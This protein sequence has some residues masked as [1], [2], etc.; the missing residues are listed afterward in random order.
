MVDV[1]NLVERQVSGHRAVSFSQR[2]LCA[3]VDERDQHSPLLVTP[4]EIL[5][6]PPPRGIEATPRRTRGG[7]RP[8]ASGPDQPHQRRRWADSR[9]HERRAGD[10][11]ARS[12]TFARRRSARALPLPRAYICICRAARTVGLTSTLR[13]IE[14]R[15]GQSPLRSPLKRASPAIGSTRTGS[16]SVVHGA[17][18]AYADGAALARRELLGQRPIRSSRRAIGRVFMCRGSSS[19]LPRGAP[20]SSLV[21]QPARASRRLLA[22]RC[23]GR[24][25]DCGG[26]SRGACSW[27]HV[28]RLPGPELAPGATIGRWGSP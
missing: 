26:A 12:L 1:V 25:S 16:G 21:R 27:T 2:E 18:Y 14:M 6:A 4:G 17:A 3:V 24:W 7:R 20:V 15:E 9:E 19:E 11:E 23:L 10:R 13:V 22:R 5:R 8:A 28:C